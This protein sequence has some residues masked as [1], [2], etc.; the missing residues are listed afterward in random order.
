MH[1]SQNGDVKRISNNSDD[2]AGAASLGTTRA[3][4]F[5]GDE[6]DV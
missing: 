5:V 3:S 2:R 4:S 1:G 6:R